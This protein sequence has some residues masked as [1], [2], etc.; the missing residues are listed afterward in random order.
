VQEPK[1]EE[2]TEQPEQPQKQQYDPA[3]LGDDDISSKLNGAAMVSGT[4][5]NDFSNTMNL[6]PGFNNGMDYNQMMQLMSGNMGT[7][8]ANFN[9]MMGKFNLILFLRTALILPSRN[10]KHGYGSNA[11]DVREHG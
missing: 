2:E 5:I 4:N 6:S 7:G 11:G 9:P 10:V 8:M 3:G 1:S